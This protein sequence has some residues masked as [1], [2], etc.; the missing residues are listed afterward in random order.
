MRSTIHAN[1]RGN[2][3][4]SISHDLKCVISEHGAAIL[5]ASSNQIFT[6]NQTGAFV[7]ERIQKGATVDEIAAELMEL[8]GAEKAVVEPGVRVFLLSLEFERLITL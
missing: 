2:E 1:F 7:W 3:V 8:T 6:L 4:I 5:N